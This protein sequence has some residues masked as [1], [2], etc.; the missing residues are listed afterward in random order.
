MKENLEKYISNVLG[1]FP[2][3]G[4]TWKYEDG[5]I[6]MGCVQLYRAT[7]KEH[8]RQFV[9]DYMEEFIAEDGI[10]KGYDPGTYNLDNIN[11]GKALF[12]VYEWTGSE[13]YRKAIEVLMEQVRRQP[14]TVSGSFWHKAIYPNQVWLDGLYMALPFYMMYE[15][16]FNQM[17]NYSDIIGQFKGARKYLFDERTGL[18]YHGCDESKK[19]FWADKK[20]GKS[21]NFWIRALGW[22]LMAL[23]DVMG[24][25]KETVFEQYIQLEELLREAV[26]GILKYQESD[27][28]MFYQVIDHPEVPDNYLETSG[29]LMVGYAILKG[30]ALGALLKEKYQETGE[31]IIEAVLNNRLVEIDGSLK[32]TGICS[33]AGLGP[34]GDT[35][36][37][38][39]IE[40]YL[41]E[42]VVSDDRKGMGVLMMASALRE[43]LLGSKF[44]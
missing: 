22:Y 23:V 14:R 40:Y 42:P 7:G 1:T 11:S 4:N 8:Y 39:S 27:S 16:K 21:K 25:M 38:G 34:E 18:Y 32:L 5:C 15:T 41:S 35:R 36:R 2:K 37:D 19:V 44:S 9:V 26:H 43:N 12:Y 28:K 20:T 6:L 17:E 29:S 24:E 13:K 31:A 30:C 3:H 33:V 10:I